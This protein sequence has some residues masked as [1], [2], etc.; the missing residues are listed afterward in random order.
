MSQKRHRQRRK[1]MPDR[2]TFPADWR[3]RLQA[4]W[5]RSEKVGVHGAPQDAPSTHY[6][7]FLGTLD[8]EL[9]F[10]APRRLQAPS[11]FTNETVLL[12]HDRADWQHVAVPMQLFAARMIE[13][14]R[15]KGI[16]LYVHSAFRT[17]KQQTALVADGRSRARWP[18]APHCI[19]EAVDIVHS[20]YH[21]ELT[22]QEWSLLGKVGKDVAAAMRL[23]VKWGGDFHTFYDPAHW[24]ILD[25]RARVRVI[26]PTPPVRKT[27][28]YILGQLRGYS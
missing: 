23:D 19:G 14:F 8:D 26:E 11:L 16:P 1:P 20:R 2:L 4:S 24:E 22:K 6:Q 25:W 9:A 7:R 5:R 15:R 13:A 3:E 27:P 21:W 18:R 17:E 12:Q 10:T 28:R